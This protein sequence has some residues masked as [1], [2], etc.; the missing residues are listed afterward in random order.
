[1]PI[2]PSLALKSKKTKEDSLPPALEV[3]V[4]VLE[5]TP[6]RANLPSEPAIYSTPLSPNVAVKTLGTSLE[7][8][9]AKK[10]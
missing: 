7:E 3:Q 8:I 1:M 4:E 10:A 2:G 5:Q 6:M 9:S